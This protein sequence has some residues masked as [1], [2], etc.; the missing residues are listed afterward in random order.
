VVEPFLEVFVPGIGWI[1]AIG[2]IVAAI[3]KYVYSKP[4][5]EFT[6]ALCERNSGQDLL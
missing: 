3:V 5:S 6:E 4:V 2:S 1:V